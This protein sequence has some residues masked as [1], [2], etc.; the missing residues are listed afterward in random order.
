ME[1]RIEDFDLA[2]WIGNWNRG[3]EIGDPV[4]G[5]GMIG[6]VDYELGIGLGDGY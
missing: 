6:I 5:I 4:L 3:L 2:F 1:I